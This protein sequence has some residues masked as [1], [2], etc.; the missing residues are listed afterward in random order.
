LYDGR[1]PR[2]VACLL[3]VACGEERAAEVAEAPARWPDLVGT[4]RGAAEAPGR[5]YVS[6]QLVVTRDGSVVATA[7]AGGV[8]LH[9]TLRI[10]A[11]DG[12]TLVVSA[13]GE[14]IAI[15]ARLEDHE[16][17]LTLPEVGEVRLRRSR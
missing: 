1:V 6:A 4:W 14:A 9:E 2:V 13:L 16:L 15:P 5:G 7:T 12:S 17:R 3:L 11:W 10:D 8:P